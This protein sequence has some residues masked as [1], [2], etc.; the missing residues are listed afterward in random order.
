MMGTVELRYCPHCNNRVKKNGSFRGKQ[1]YICTFELCKKSVQPV[2]KKI[3]DDEPDIKCSCGRKP[4]KN[5]SNNGR[6]RYF[7]TICNKPVSKKP[8]KVLNSK[9]IE[10]ILYSWVEFNYDYSRTMEKYGIT[11]NKLKKITKEHSKLT[12]RIEGWLM[13]KPKEVK[14][15]FGFLS[16]KQIYEKWINSNLELGEFARSLKIGFYKARSI[17][18]QELNINEDRRA[19]ESAKRKIR[20]E[21][22]L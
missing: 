4:K 3:K 19:L 10:A 14:T 7:C 18:A 5:G 9:E 21:R 2:R 17:I 1:R 13:K 12:E 16:N 20:K 6:Q 22:G 8:Y 15:A 11:R